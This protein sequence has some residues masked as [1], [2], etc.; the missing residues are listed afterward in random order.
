MI[1]A[2]ALGHGSVVGYRYRYPGRHRFVNL[3]APSFVERRIDEEVGPLIER[4]HVLGRH[5]AQSP[6]IIRELTAL[7][8]AV[9]LR[10]RPQ[11]PSGDYEL[12]RQPAPALQTPKCL[13]QTLK[14]LP[15]VELV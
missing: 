14:V 11:G 7:Y 5:I 12:M 13:N 4:Q 8:A 3:E 9:E 6:D 2:S 1:D 15:R 10:V